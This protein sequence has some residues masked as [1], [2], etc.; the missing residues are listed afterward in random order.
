MAEWMVSIGAAILM[1]GCG[2]MFGE[3][4]ELRGK[5][6]D[7]EAVAA[8]FRKGII[9]NR[10]IRMAVQVMVTAG[11]VMVSIGVTLGL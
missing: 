10:W 9:G 6:D 2:L 7:P 11:L 5:R 4:M 3:I 1:T 8:L